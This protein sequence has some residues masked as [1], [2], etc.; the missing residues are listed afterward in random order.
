[1]DAPPFTHVLG[2]RVDAIGAE[3]AVARIVLLARAPAAELGPR[4]VVTLGTEM[5][6]RA[7]RDPSFRALLDGA[8]L[9]LCD[10]IGIRLA[11]RAYGL[12]IPQRVTGVDLVDP[13]ARGLAA[14]GLG[15][16]LLGARG[17]TAAR[18]GAELARRHP[19]L[20]ICG[21]RDG[22]FREEESASVA[23]EIARS[24]A[25]VLLVGLGSPRQ[26]W[27]I[28]RHLAAT[29]AGAGIGVGGSLD[30]I[31]GNLERAPLA[32]RRAGL[33]WFYRLLR[34]PSRLRRQLALPHFVFLVAI[35]RLRAS[36]KA[37][38]TR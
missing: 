2:C 31:S 7:R 5:A 25:R 16:Y 18:A 22:Y 35:D 10:T 27:W 13:L 21:A 14:Q 37:N 11:A 30:V 38:D 29:G 12:R 4:L 3:A 20:Q 36:R 34:E 26:E 15:L 9:S 24:G 8:A 19:G 23:A 17:D 28:E 6:V 32:F 33:E 1:V